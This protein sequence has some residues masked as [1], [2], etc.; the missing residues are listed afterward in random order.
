M[1]EYDYR[2]NRDFSSIC[3][4]PYMETDERKLKIAKT[5]S[6]FTNAPIFCIPL[7]LIICISISS[8]GVPFTASF[9]FDWMEFIACELISIIFTSIL[10]MAII[11]HWAKKQDTDSD[12]SNKEDRFIPLI[13]G[14]V[15]YFIGCILSV[16]L[17]LPHFLTVLLLCYTTNTF[18]VM[19]ITTRWKISIHTTGIAGPIAAVTM[20]LGPV[21]ALFGVLYPILIWSRTTLKKHTMAQALAGGIFGLIFTILETYIYSI[22]LNLPVT[23]IIPAYDSF[24]LIFAI[25]I[26]PIVI[27]IVGYL[28]DSG[29]KDFITRKLFHIFAFLG[30]AFFLILAPNDAI[31]IL[32]ICAIVT[33]LVSIY[34]NKNFSWYNGIKIKEDAPKESYGIIVSLV[35]SLFWILASLFYFSRT[36]A[37]ISTVILAF[38]GAIEILYYKSAHKRLPLK[39]IDNLIIPLVI[40]YV[41]K[42]IL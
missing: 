9:S 33:I 27:S 4:D 36:I 21:G 40:A 32:I 13:V 35:S 30:Y 22:L 19:L 20:I 31:L 1:A 23:N 10:P 41:L 29:K 34:G 5:I 24:W 42:F 6:T 25:M 37:A 15:S 11:I 26:S 28:Q 12:I 8:R 3:T 39:G 2:T 18:I 14:T 17:N 38:V 16:L 7:F